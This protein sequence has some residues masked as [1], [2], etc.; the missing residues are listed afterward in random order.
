MQISRRTLLLRI[1]GRCLSEM[2]QPSHVGRPAGPIRLDTN[3]NAYGPSER[4]SR[5][6]VKGQASLTAIRVRN[7]MTWPIGSPVCTESRRSRWS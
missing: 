4:R 7:A 5:R 3:E 2:L 6:C 1:N